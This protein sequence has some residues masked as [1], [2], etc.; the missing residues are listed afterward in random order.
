MCKDYSDGDWQSFIISL[1]RGKCGFHQFHDYPI[2]LGQKVL[3]M[4]IKLS[5][6]GMQELERWISWQ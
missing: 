3:P 1:L 6:T 4:R 2:Y 5:E